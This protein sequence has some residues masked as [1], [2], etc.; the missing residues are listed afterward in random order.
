M[1]NIN[2]KTKKAI[3]FYCL[4]IFAF[5]LAF[6]GF[7]ICTNL[8][9][10]KRTMGIL[11]GLELQTK[12]FFGFKFIKCYI[13]WHN[14]EKPYEQIGYFSH[15]PNELSNLRNKI[16][17]FHTKNEL[18]SDT[19]R[20]YKMSYFDDGREITIKSF[21]R[22]RLRMEKYLYFLESFIVFYFV[23]FKFKKSTK[24]SKNIDNYL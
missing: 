14:N 8:S 19:E 5:L 21:V 23:Y 9:S 3:F 13:L 16:V 1:F 7:S 18:F 4:V 24:N 22:T 2:S 11:T 12:S 10:T 6:K 17:T 15:C 20:I